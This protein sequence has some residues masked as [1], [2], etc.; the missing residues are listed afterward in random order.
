MVEDF[1]KEYAKLISDSPEIIRTER[2][3]LGENFDEIIIYASK[4]DTGKLIG[5]DGKMINAIKTVVIGYK[6][7]DPTSYRITVKAIEEWSSRGL[8]T[9]QNCRAK[10]G[11][12]AS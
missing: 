6:A 5:K 2:I 3:N 11:F 4:A 1:L 9:W 8:H 7:K 10:G 12:K